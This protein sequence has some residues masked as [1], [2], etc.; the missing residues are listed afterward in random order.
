MTRK[1]QL[2]KLLRFFKN[3]C[4]IKISLHGMRKAHCFLVLF[5]CEIGFSTGSRKICNKTNN[6]L[7]SK[8]NIHKRKK[9]QHSNSKFF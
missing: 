9:I 4:R 1:H 3:Y 6:K 2:Y 7:D 8:L 5:S